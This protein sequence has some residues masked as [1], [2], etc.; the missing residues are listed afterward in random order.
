M[1]LRQQLED[2]VKAAMRAGDATTRDTL[3][4]VLAVVKSKEIDSDSGVGDDDVKAALASAL[5]TRRESIEQFVQGG[6]EDLA[7]IERAQIAVLER[8]LPKQLSEDET[9]AALKALID[10]LGVSSKKDMGRVMKELMA[11]H[12]GTVDGKLAG[13]LVGELLG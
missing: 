6:R 12:K 1:S 8:Y 5:K 3:R 7:E 11:R 2:D 9:R 13:R 4:M 10:E